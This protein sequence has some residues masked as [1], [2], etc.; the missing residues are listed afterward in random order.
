MRVFFI[1]DLH[2]NSVS[3]DNYKLFVKFFTSLPTDTQ[4]VYILGDL[5]E[6]WIDDRRNTEFTTNVKQILHQ[7]STICPIFFMHGNRDFLLGKLFAKQTNI[8]LLPELSIIN[9]YNKKIIL[10]H[11]DLL[12]T[13][14]KSHIYYSKIIRHPIMLYIANLV[15]LKYKLWAAKL[16]RKISA[17]NK[18]KTQTITANDLRIYDIYQPT[19]DKLMQQH[20]ADIIIHGHTHKPNIYNEPNYTRIVLGEWQNQAKILECTPD[21]CEL[22]TIR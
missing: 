16:L 19:V 5:F 11:G 22:K 6:A 13:L 7:A 4:A 18:Y 3:E 21:G 1:S 9:L 14:D 15:P 2:L 8:T 17:G 20:S 12:C 10:S